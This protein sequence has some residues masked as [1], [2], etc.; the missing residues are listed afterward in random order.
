MKSMLGMIDPLV[1]LY[2]F[3]WGVTTIQD[4]KRTTLFLSGMTVFVINFEIFVPVLFV[5]LAIFILNNA[6]C[7]R[8]YQP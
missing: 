7:S 1:D 3:I 4:T 6:Y 8:G 2:E 5:G